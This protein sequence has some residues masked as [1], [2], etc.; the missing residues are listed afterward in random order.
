MIRQEQAGVDVP[1]PSFLA[2][3]DCKVSGICSIKK[4]LF[5]NLSELTLKM[6]VKVIFACSLLAES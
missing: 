5:Q 3:F 1:S 4:K 2:G 6:Q